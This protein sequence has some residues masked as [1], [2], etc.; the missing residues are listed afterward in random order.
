LRIAPLDISGCLGCDA[1]KRNGGTCVGDLY[2]KVAEAD[3]NALAHPVYFYTWS[4][5]TKAFLDRLYAFA[6]DL[7]HDKDSY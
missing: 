1:C 3:M 4:T 7:M 5:Q 6:P 2:P